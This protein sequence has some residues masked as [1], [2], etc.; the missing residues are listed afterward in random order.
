MTAVLYGPKSIA[1]DTI[2][3]DLLV[4]ICPTGWKI[5]DSVKAVL[6]PHGSMKNM[7]KL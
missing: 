5:T 2:H 6:A 3:E 1:E 7:I 4:C